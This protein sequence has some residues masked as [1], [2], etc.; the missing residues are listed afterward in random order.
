MLEWWL[1]Y[2]ELS[3]TVVVAIPFSSKYFSLIAMNV[4]F[5][6]AFPIRL[7]SRFSDK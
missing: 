3:Y 4:L 2:F 5:N 1:Q 7:W 6:G